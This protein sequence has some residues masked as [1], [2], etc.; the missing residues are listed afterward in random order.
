M[1]RSCS[2]SSSTRTSSACLS[3]SH[4]SR[5]AC[6][7]ATMEST[8]VWPFLAAASAAKFSPTSN[9]SARQFI[10]DVSLFLPIEEVSLPVL[11]L[12]TSS[13]SSS[14]SSSSSSAGLSQALSCSSPSNVM[15]VA[16][17]FACLDIS[18]PSLWEG[19][20]DVE[21]EAS[22]AASL[23]AALTTVEVTGVSMSS[24]AKYAG[25]SAADAAIEVVH[26]LLSVRL[27]GRSSCAPVSSLSH[28]DSEGL[29]SDALSDTARSKPVRLDGR[30]L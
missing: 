3:S 14:T 28:P 7:K 26:R 1:D 8:E 12:T 27:I 4:R 17:R 9:A 10:E 16:L 15:R 23:A 13:S 5:S 30:S 22:L 25:V 19:R 24:R 29:L 18:L 11:F 21:S 20:T 6:T 2:C